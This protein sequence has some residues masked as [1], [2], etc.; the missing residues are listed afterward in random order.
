MPP[1]PCLTC[2]RPM[3]GPGSRH[4][5]CGGRRRT[6]HERDRRAETVAAWRETQGDWCPGYRRAAHEAHDLTADHTIPVAA[7]GREDGPLDVL[8]RAC[9]ARK[10]DGR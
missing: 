10:R 5:E 4:P 6:W 3:I 9:N 1:K 7:G 8:C 2:R